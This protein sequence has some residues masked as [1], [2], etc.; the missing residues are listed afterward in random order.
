MG[1]L[2]DGLIDPFLAFWVQGQGQAASVTA[3]PSAAGQARRFSEDEL[4]VVS[5]SLRSAAGTERDEVFVALGAG[6]A[7]AGVDALD[8]YALVPPADAYVLLAAEVADAAGEPVGLAIDHRPW[9]SVVEVPLA[10]TAVGTDGD[11]VLAWAGLDG[12]DVP[13][14]AT[15]TL[16]D[17]ETGARYDL[18]Q[19]GEVAFSVTSADAARRATAPAA[20]VPFR[21]GSATARRAGPRFVVTVTS[22]ATSA[23]DDAP[24]VTALS[25]PRPNPTAGGTTLTLTLAEAGNVRAEVFDVLGRRV[26]SVWDGPLGIGLHDL[27]VQRGALSAGTYVVRVTTARTTLTRSLTVV[28]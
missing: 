14:G 3:N 23:G 5:L 8:G 20:P 15:V 9:E 16:E 12:S 18:R 19:S 4:A 27:A 26:A 7:T 21:P 10:V 22:L 6:G 17:R 2:T 25:A 1:N 24:T 11:L 28:R 13:A